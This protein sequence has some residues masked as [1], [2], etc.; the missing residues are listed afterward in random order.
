MSAILHGQKH[1]LGVIVHLFALCSS[2][3]SENHLFFSLFLMGFLRKV[4]F[5]QVN[6][7]VDDIGEKLP[8]TL[9]TAHD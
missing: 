8:K 7:Q 2:Q 6:C 4:Q 5:N 3:N 1:A 9:I